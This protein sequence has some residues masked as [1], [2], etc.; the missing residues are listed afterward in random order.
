MHA[1]LT[2]AGYQAIGN[3]IGKTFDLHREDE[4]LQVKLPYDNDFPKLQS[5]RNLIRTGRSF[6]K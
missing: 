2:H 6:C 4:F 5:L 1:D 3:I